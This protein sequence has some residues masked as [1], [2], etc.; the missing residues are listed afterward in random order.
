M[1]ERNEYGILFKKIMI[2]IDI[3]FA[4]NKYADAYRFSFY[5]WIW[6]RY[7]KRR[8]VEGVLETNSVVLVIWSSLNGNTLTN[9][10]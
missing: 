5:L 1:Y 3:Y 2:N 10:H 8:K 4:E 9:K 6:N 7:H